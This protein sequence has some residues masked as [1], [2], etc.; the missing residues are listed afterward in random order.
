MY[1]PSSYVG[2]Y[3]FLFAKYHANRY[4]SVAHCHAD[5]KY[6]TR[7]EESAD[8]C[9]WKF[10]TESTTSNGSKYNI[11]LGGKQYLIQQNW[12]NASGGYCAMSY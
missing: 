9:A 4:L 3:P 1:P 12:V 10:G 8:K 6:D 7:G 11:T 5:S 2:N